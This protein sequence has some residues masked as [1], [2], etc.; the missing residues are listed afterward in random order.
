MNIEVD[1]ITLQ[2]GR[3]RALDGA[4]ASFSEG[5]MGLLGPNGA[6]KT[7][8]LKVLLGFLTPTTGSAKVLGMDVAAR[9]LDVRQAV[10]FMP[11]ID[12]HIPGMNAV[13]LCT[14]AG[15]LCGMPR[16]E[17]IQRAHEA[18]Y[19]A[20]LGEARYRPVETYS[21]GMKQR[22]KLAQALVH[23]PRLLFLDEPTNGLDPK[24]RIEMLALIKDLSRRKGVN[25]V[26]SSHILR[27]VEETCTSV[28]MLARGKVVKQGS[29]AELKKAV[30]NL[31][32]VRVKGEAEERDRFASAV[33]DQGATWKP[34]DDGLLEV[35]LNNGT[36][37][38]A[39]FQAASNAE[40]QIRHLRRRVPSLEEIFA[41]AV[42]LDGGSQGD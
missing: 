42:G 31:Y 12:C 26:L 23:G 4:T 17:A 2:Y 24:G 13:Q 35:T 40:V 30:S 25:V 33:I 27:D 41:R 37:S 38:E 1:N 32:E 9:P 39:V 11:E 22:A 15:E 28:V 6:G 16:I 18:L 3:F 8:L 5:A 34:M 21:T 20:N 14:Y 29:I 10:G 36:G 19:Y 7:S